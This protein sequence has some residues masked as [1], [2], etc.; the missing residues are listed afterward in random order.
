MWNF[1]NGNIPKWKGLALFSL[2]VGAY[3]SIK[4]GWIVGIQAFLF[5]LCVSY[6]FEFINNKIYWLLLRTTITILFWIIVAFAVTVF[7]PIRHIEA[8]YFIAFIP[9]VI[10]IGADIYETIK[11]RKRDK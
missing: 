6:F 8:L 9:S 3:Q 2:I 1:L 11:L 10:L 4:D 7:L 5:I